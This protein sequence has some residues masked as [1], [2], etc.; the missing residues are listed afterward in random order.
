MS[1]RKGPRRLLFSARV[2]EADDAWVR[3]RAAA[4]DTDFATFARR[5][6]TFARLTM[7]KGWTPPEEKISNDGE[8]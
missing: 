8:P 3:S 1:P 4:E 5:I 7:P 6:L 2:D